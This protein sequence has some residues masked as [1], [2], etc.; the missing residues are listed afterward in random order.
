MSKNDPEIYTNIS[1]FDVMIKPI[2]LYGCEVWG[3]EDIEQIDVFDRNFLRRL[4]RKQKS[5]P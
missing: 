2:L 3:H 1:L 5:A 4:L